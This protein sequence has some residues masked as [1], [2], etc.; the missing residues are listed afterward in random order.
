LKAAGSIISPKPIAVQQNTLL[1][2]GGAVTMRVVY[3]Q[4]SA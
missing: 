1:L 2:L 4:S 3:L